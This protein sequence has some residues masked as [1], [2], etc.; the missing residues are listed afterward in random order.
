MDSL[1][2]VLLLALVLLGTPVCAVAALA[3]A[4]KLKGTVRDL[5]GRLAAAEAVLR[6]PPQAVAAAPALPAEPPPPAAEPAAPEPQPPA[7]EPEP[8]PEA[9][10]PAVPSIPPS[11]SAEPTPAAGRRLEEQLGTRWAVWIGGLALA[12]GG[13]F[14]VRYSIERGLLGPGARI[15]AGALFALALIAA[16]EWLRRRES[17]FS[18]ARIPSAH[19]P[20]VLTGAGTIAAFA[21]IYAAHALYG[22][23]GPAAAF[24]LLGATALL[25]M[26]ASALHGPALAGLGLVG[27]LAT[28]LFV[29]S[30]AP[31]V[32][33]VVLYLAFAVAASYGV[34]RMRLWRW[35]AV[36]GAAGALAWG[37]LFVLNA[38]DGAW[39]PM[40]H[41]ALQAGL[42][43][44]FLA[45]DPHRATR[46]EE[47]GLDVLASLVLAGFA[48]LAVA[49]AA[50][51]D[52]G[53][54]RPLFCGAL[55]AWLAALAIRFAPVAPAGLWAGLCL[56]GTLFFWPVASEVA[57]EP[58]MVLPGPFGLP[59]RPE[60]LVGFLTFA[61]LGS[62]LPAAG[63]LWRV[64]RAGGLRRDLLGWYCA[65]A[66]LS[67]LAAL[68]VA[69][70]RVTA[71]DRSI[72]F[73][74]AA[75]LLGLLY[76]GAA[77]LLHASAGERER[78]ALPIGAAASASLAALALG[79]TFAL[80]KGMLTVAFALAA[81]GT[82]YVSD[83]TGV[84]ALRKAV[85]AAAILV[86]AR[87]AFSPT[88]VGGSPGSTPIFNWL[89]WG[90]GVPALAFGLA[91]RILERSGRDNVVRLVESLAIAFAFFLVFFEI[92]HAL[93]GDIASEET[94]HLEAGLTAASALLFAIVLTRLDVARADPVYRIGAS[95]FSWLAVLIAA[96]GLVVTA[97]PL[98][99]GDVVF[100]GAVFNSLLPAYLLPAILA[101]I[102]AIAAQRGGRPTYYVRSM[103]VLALV[104]Q[105]CWLV[106][107]V[108]RFFH[109]PDEMDLG[110]PTSEAEQWAYSLALLACGL[111][112]LAVGAVRRS[113][114]LRLASLVFLALAVLKV[115]VIDLSS[116]EGIMRAL[117]FIGLGLTLIGIALAYQRLLAR[118]D[119]ASS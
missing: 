58:V 65:A 51:P 3:V 85:A 78:L 81:L 76:A 19:I 36:A 1:G 30:Q 47:A 23:L 7:A 9:A 25:T 69:Y 115:F 12:L 5:E 53:A 31:K 83:R 117:S 40:L 11:P 102:L 73:A 82:A 50:H 21:T 108:R 112:L 92:R 17:A 63:I 54:L 26:V 114:I 110:F 60:A 74:L 2:L 119:E 71:F 75:G 67:P 109:G 56:A 15:A 13:V 34:A 89:L 66:T 38:P 46:D 70:A 99:S 10:R 57:A 103:A 39:P 107:A 96:V 59:T 6:V 91:A 90:Y 8:I 33:P 4:V 100:G 101:G 104:L 16:G 22:M 88:I 80:D 62:L 27:A 42:A 18:L 32:L 86:L 45:A 28:P 14:L 105:L 84:P 93:R 77:R 72:P 41:V 98:F 35:L 95:L 29:S 37:V 48:L 111:V 44:L 68:V 97:N 87:L 113:R 64:V 118:P 116:L 49:T 24:G 55:V 20:G 94:D 43:G 79:L 106:L 61:A 52:A